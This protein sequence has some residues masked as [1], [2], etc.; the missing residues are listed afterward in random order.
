[1]VVVIIVIHGQSGCNR[2]DS[3][4]EAILLFGAEIPK[5]SDHYFEYLEE[6]EE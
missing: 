1:M 3:R 5:P 2:M 4:F 6:G